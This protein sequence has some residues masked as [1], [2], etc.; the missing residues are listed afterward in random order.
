MRLDGKSDFDFAPFTQSRQRAMP[1]R[2]VGSQRKFWALYGSN[3][4][5]AVLL[6]PLEMPARGGGRALP[7]ALTRLIPGRKRKMKTK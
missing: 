1:V 2:R 5:P 3:T 6:A 7:G 4:S